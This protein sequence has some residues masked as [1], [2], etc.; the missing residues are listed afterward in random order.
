MTCMMAGS[1]ARFFLPHM[2]LLRIM[3]EGLVEG[4]SYKIA[5]TF[6][7]VLEIS[8]I[9]SYA[10]ICVMYTCCMLTFMITSNDVSDVMR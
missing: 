1:F 2:R 8:V 6:N 4:D 3:P 7:L 9:F 5:A 10:D